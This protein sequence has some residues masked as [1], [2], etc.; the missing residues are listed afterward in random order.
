MVSISRLGFNLALLSL[1][2]PA[3]RPKS[4][5]P[6]GRITFVTT[7]PGATVEVDGE[8]LDGVT[9][10]VH[11][12]Q[13]GRSRAARFARYGYEDQRVGFPIPPAASEVTATLE[14]A[15]LIEVTTEP[16]GAAV[17]L[18]S[19][20][21]L[22]ETPGK[23][24]LNRGEHVLTLRLVDYGNA[25][26]RVS[27]ADLKPIHIKLSKEAFLHIEASSPGANILVDDF[28]VGAVTPVN[29]LSVPS[30][31]SLR[32]QLKLDKLSTPAF[33]VRPLKPGATFAI[34]GVL[35]DREESTT[36]ARLRELGTQIAGLEARRLE[37][38]QASEVASIED[39]EKNLE[40]SRRLRATEDLLDQLTD[41]KDQLLR[42]LE[43]LRSEAHP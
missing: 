33:T 19:R 26:L 36:Q 20:T 31:T 42:H 25:R 41:E 24:A 23:V 40:N 4:P 43:K 27:A 2:P 35:R 29:R 3:C 34:H 39:V 32:V 13:P 14:P 7:P 37:L 12:F 18:D 38:R 17:A 6:R 28:D 10:M 9:P 21:V 30:G 5:E 22:Q 1:A 8:P 15:P 11:E 16:A